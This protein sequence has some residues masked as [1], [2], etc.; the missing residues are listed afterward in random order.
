MSIAEAVRLLEAEK[1]IAELLCRVADLEAIAQA[2]SPGDRSE[3]AED[4]LRDVL[5]AG[6]VEAANIKRQAVTRG[7]N[8]RTVQRARER[9]GAMS[10][11]E[12]FGKGSRVLWT[13]PIDDR[14]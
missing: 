14:G 4:W 11:R 7:F 6:Q 12:G 13:M 10:T 5:S 9:I 1:K 3:T 8:W 2:E